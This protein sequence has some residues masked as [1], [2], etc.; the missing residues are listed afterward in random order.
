MVPLVRAIAAVVE[1][2]L[3]AYAIVGGIAVAARLGHAHRATSDV[4]AVVDET[5]PPDAVE[6]LLSRDDTRA[7]PTA[8]HRVY[9]EGTRV[10]I[11]GVGPL[12]EADL[13]GVPDDDALFVAA[14]SWALGTAMPLTLIAMTDETVTA[15]APFA[16]PGAL[17]A[18]KLHAI[19]TRSATSAD[20]RS[21]DAWDLY[22]LLLDLD[23]GA[24]VGGQLAAAPSRLRQLVAEAANHVLGSG[25]N[26]TVGWLRGGD[27]QMASVT[28]D[29]LRYLAKPLIA[30]LSR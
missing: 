24:M 15:T 26:R 8:P 19:Q 21:A 18:M 23:A 12:D 17:V 25:A 16:T 27:D 1:S 20:K 6:A 5:T 14:H 29:E 11:L 28:A 9:V 10:E 13:D 30:G 7:D 22:R 2:D 4:D 3:G